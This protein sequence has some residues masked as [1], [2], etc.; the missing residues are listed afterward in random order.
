[1]LL[2]IE[3]VKVNPLAFENKVRE[4]SSLLQVD[5]NWLMLVMFIE[6]SLDASRVNP[7]TGATGLIQF[8][9]STAVKL[10]TTL[11]A[12]KSMSGVAQLDYVYKYLHPY[13][14]K[15]KTYLDLYLAIFFPSHIGM[16]LDTTV[17]SS[18]LSAGL[19]AK[20][21]K[22]YDLNK[23]GRI[24]LEEI[25]QVLTRRIPPSFAAAFEILKKKD[26]RALL[27]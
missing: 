25:S 3:K 16:P 1:M 19:I 4:I 18:R 20:Q 23:D 27:S 21:N 13:K 6:S 2:Y 11:Q 15:L 12:L 10:G 24:T 22:G 9:P 5:P 26:Q 14:G 8:M 17:Q 7:M